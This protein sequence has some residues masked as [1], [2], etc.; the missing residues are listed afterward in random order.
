MPVEYTSAL[1]NTTVGNHRRKGRILNISIV[2][3]SFWNVGGNSSTHANLT[4]WQSTSDQSEHLDSLNLRVRTAIH[5]IE[6][7]NL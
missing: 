6:E 2:A 5:A 7:A 4:C 1:N 3:V